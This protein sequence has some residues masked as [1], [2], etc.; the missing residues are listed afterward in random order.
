MST[1]E[2]SVD[3]VA[4]SGDDLLV[5][6]AARVSFR[7]RSTWAHRRG[8][9]GANGGV[10]NHDRLSEQDRRLLGY[11]ARHKHWTPF[12]HPQ[13]TL[14][15]KAPVFVARQCF[16]HKVGFVENEI[17]RR[18]VDENPRFFFPKTWRSRADDKKQGSGAPLPVQGAADGLYRAACI[19]AT[20]A[21]HRLLAD[22]VAPEQ[23][24]MVLPQSML[25]EWIWTG[26]LAAWARF[27][28]QR[29]TS[30]AQEETRQV[31]LLA[32]AIV[33]SKFPAAWGALL[34]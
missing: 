10:Y 1:S 2:I 24:R 27:C 8:E 25:T 14:H 13:I 11:L 22:G 21:Y 4:H 7:K 16:K 32:A 12:A 18:Y 9:I 28:A 17:S 31:A 34:S 26:S 20:F 33:G 19:A 6:N 23:A 30:N 5:V 29:T 15:I 3:Y